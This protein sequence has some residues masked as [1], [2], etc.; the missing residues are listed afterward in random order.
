MTSPALVSSP[1]LDV[2]RRLLGFCDASPSPYHACATA[3]A[4]LGEAG[5]TRLAEDAV[6]PGEPGRWL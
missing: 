3:A 4:M 5:F 6:W 2:A 1:A